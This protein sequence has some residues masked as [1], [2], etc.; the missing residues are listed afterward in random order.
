MITIEIKIIGSSLGPYTE[1]V[2]ALCM[3]LAL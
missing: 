2:K 1:D 3:D